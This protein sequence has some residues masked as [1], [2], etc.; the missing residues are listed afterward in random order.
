MA[1]IVEI[2]EGVEQITRIPSKSRC[3]AE[4]KKVLPGAHFARAFMAPPGAAEAVPCVELRYNAPGSH[5]TASFCAVPVEIDPNKEAL[6]PLVLIRHVFRTYG[7][8]MSVREVRNTLAR[9]WRFEY[10]PIKPP[11]AAQ[12]DTEKKE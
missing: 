4:V 8:E 5:G 3:L 2:V 10:E 9:E 12:P 7:Y 1:Q 11:D 6:I